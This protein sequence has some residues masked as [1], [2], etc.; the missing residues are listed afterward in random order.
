MPTQQSPYAIA[1]FC[2]ITHT[3]GQFSLSTVTVS[4]VNVRGFSTPAARVTWSTTIPPECVTSVTVNFRT[5]S[6]GPVVATYTTNSTSETEFI[7]T[8]LQCTTYYYI[9]VVV[10]GQL[11]D[12]IHPTLSSRQVQVAVGG[13]KKKRKKGKRKKKFKNLHE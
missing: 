3:A 6:S 10:T 11:S 13:K 8:D 1:A 2:I 4:A 5:A 7:Q 12:G 9:R